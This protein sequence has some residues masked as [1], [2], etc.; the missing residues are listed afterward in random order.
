LQ[1][2]AKDGSRGLK[3]HVLSCVACKSMVAAT[4]LT[5]FPSFTSH[6]PSVPAFLKSE[7]ADTVFHV[8]K[9]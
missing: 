4:K 1:W 5:D 6:M 2:K 8:L 3:A 9:K 7:V